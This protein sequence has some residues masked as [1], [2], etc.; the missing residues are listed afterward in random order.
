MY[1][2]TLAQERMPCGAE[3]S[4][5]F[6]HRF[7]RCAAWSSTPSVD[8]D[9]NAD[10]DDQVPDGGP[11]PPDV[12]DSAAELKQARARA[13]WHLKSHIASAVVRGNKPILDRYLHN[14]AGTAIRRRRS[15]LLAPC[16]LRMDPME[17][18][19]DDPV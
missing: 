4:G 8:A 6:G 15:P 18:E 19:S 3:P 12:V 11:L 5:T 17:L 1:H 16:P 14:C 2:V 10:D 9:P 7:A 13:L